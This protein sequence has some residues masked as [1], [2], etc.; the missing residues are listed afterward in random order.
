MFKIFLFGMIIVMLP[1][2]FRSRF[3]LCSYWGP[4]MVTKSSICFR[5]CGL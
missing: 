1:E 4:H 3:V 2:L 5:S